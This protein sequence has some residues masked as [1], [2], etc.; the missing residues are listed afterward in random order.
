[1]YG[2]GT[3]LATGGGEGGGALGG[4]FK[5]VALD[6]QDRMKLTGDPAKASVPGDKRVWRAHT[7]QG[8]L[9]MDVIT[10]LDDP[11][12]SPASVS[13]TYQPLGSRR[14]P[15]GLTW[16]DPRVVVMDGGVRRQPPEPLIDLQARARAEIAALPEG[17]RR[18][19]N[20]HRYHVSLGAPCRRGVTR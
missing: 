6:G 15:A 1:M 10:G 13:A 4:V 17:T 7:G 19:L 3:Q 20:P 18:L 2:V 9:V 12:R 5:L 11:R 14:V 16:T 8:G